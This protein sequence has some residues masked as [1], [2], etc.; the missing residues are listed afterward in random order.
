MA[1]KK[2][3]ELTETTLLEAEDLFE[4]A[5]KISEGVYVNKKVKFSNISPSGYPPQTGA[6]MGQVW[7]LNA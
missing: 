4:I 1:D 2:I 5:E 3:S 7:A 6:D